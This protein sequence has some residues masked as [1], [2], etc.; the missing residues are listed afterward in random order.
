M[1]AL[2]CCRE[3][4]SCGAISPS[5]ALALIAPNLPIPSGLTVGHAVAPATVPQECESGSEVDILEH[6][7]PA[8]VCHALRAYTAEV[9]ILL[10]PPPRTLALLLKEEPLLHYF[11]RHAE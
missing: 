7:A 11:S 3:Q 4:L 9:Q 5:T 6:F 2:R 1:P 10:P 8:V